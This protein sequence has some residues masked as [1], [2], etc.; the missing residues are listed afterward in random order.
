MVLAMLSDRQEPLCDC[1][2]PKSKSQSGQVEPEAS[3][4]QFRIALG[5]HDAAGESPLEQPGGGG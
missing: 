2:S 4:H 5:E 1:K 3:G